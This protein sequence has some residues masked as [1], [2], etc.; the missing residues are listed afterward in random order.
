MRATI[1]DLRY[2][3]KDILRALDRQETVEIFYHDKKKGTIIPVKT[4]EKK[5][6]QDHPIFGMLSSKT[7][8]EKVLSKLRGGRYSD[9]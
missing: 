3:M 7:S 4:S 9:I 6:V 2:H 5:F 1:L 8:V